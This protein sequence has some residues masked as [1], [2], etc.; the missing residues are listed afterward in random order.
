MST[1][2][3]TP[4]AGPIQMELPEETA[5]ARNDVRRAMR[6]LR[7]EQPQELAQS[8]SAAAQQRLMRWPLWQQARSVALYVGVRGE[9]AT[10]DILQAA[11][12]ENKVVWLP[13]V[14][15]D[16]PGLMDFVACGG[17]QQLRPGP[18]GLLEPVDTLPGVGPEG[19]MRRAPQPDQSGPDMSGPDMFG[20]D[21]FGPDQHTALAFAPDLALLPGV[22]FDRAGGRLGYGGGYYDRFLEKSLNCPCVGLCFEF[23]LVPSLPLAPWDQRV[24]YI[25]TEERI[26][27]L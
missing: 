18:M 20:P 21:M 7:A 25:C 23:Q 15:P 5:R 16:A 8:R 27:C 22:A 12:Q 14:R 2:P 10:N 1:N 19:L 26:L 24:N 11:W 3:Q 9:L 17:P 6:R 13:R 4:A